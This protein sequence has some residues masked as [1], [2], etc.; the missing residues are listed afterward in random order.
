MRMNEDIWLSV[1][2]SPI[3]LCQKSMRKWDNTW[4]LVSIGTCSHPFMHFSSS[5]SSTGLDL[6]CFT[7][8]SGLL[9]CL[10]KF[11]GGLLTPL[12]E[13][14]MS[15]TNPAFFSVA[16]CISR[17]QGSHFRWLGRAPK[18]PLWDS[19]WFHCLSLLVCVVQGLQ[20]AVWYPTT[21]TL[22][23][24]RPTAQ[25]TGCL[26]NRYFQ[27]SN[28]SRH[29]CLH[30]PSSSPAGYTAHLVMWSFSTYRIDAIPAHYKCA[31]ER[32]QTVTIIMSC[33]LDCLQQTQTSQSQ[34]TVYL[35]PAGIQL[36]CWVS[37]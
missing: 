34:I 9:G 23:G 14:K 35:Q 19:H 16:W 32:Q 4:G 22:W 6:W 18:S 37:P 27:S 5:S 20:A 8:V 30:L 29:L 10:E 17:C 28:S 24:G 13:P 12:P 33:T 7:H 2:R 15:L 21:N 26:S 31:S 1:V 3:R 36:S 25:S 11:S